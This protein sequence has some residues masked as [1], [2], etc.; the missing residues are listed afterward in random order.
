MTFYVGQKV[1]FGRTHGEKTLG[2]IVKINPKKIKIRQLESRGTMKSYPVGTI[3]GV[4]PTFVTPAPE[5]Q[6]VQAQAPRKLTPE[7]AEALAETG[8]LQEYLKRTGTA[9]F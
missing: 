6:A 2:E 4:P 1:L 5:G 9:P 8:L 7:L 3:W